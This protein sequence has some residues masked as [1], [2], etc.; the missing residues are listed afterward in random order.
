MWPNPQFPVTFSAEI[1][2]GRLHFLCGDNFSIAHDQA[3]ATISR[4]IFE[5]K[6]SFCVGWCTAGL[7]DVFGDF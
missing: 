1:L 7:I 4:G 2:N 3:G 5:T 6:A